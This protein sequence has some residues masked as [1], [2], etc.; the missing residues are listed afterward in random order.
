MLTFDKY[1]MKGIKIANK[2][3]HLGVRGI[4]SNWARIQSTRKRT[5]VIGVTKLLDALEEEYGGKFH[6]RIPHEYYKN[7]SR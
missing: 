5:S 1:E 7:I 2:R 3:A 6:L 4:H